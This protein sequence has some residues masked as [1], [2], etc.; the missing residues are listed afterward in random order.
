[1]MKSAV[2][3]CPPPTF[4]SARSWPDSAEGAFLHRVLK[5][6]AALDHDEAIRLL[7]HQTDQTHRRAELVGAERRKDEILRLHH[8]HGPHRSGTVLEPGV[9]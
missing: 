7:N 3:I 4:E 9:T 1:M 5:T 2:T 6:D 8:R